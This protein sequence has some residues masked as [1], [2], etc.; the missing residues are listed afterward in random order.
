MEKRLFRYL[1]PD[2]IEIRKGSFI[3]K[4]KDRVE[5]LPYKTARVDYAL[6]D[7]T[8]GPFNWCVQ[9]KTENNILFAGIGIKDPVS[10]VFVFKWNAGD[11]AED[12][13][14]YGKALAS[15]SV[16]RSGFSWGLG[17]ELYGTPRVVVPN[18]NTSYKCTEFECEDGKVVKYTIVDSKGEQVYHYEPGY[19][20]VR[21]G[22]SELPEVDRQLPWVEQ[23][24][25]FCTQMKDQTEDPDEH[26][27]LRAFYSY[28]KPKDKKGLSYGPAKCYKFFLSDVKDGTIEIDDADPKHP[29][30]IWKG[31]KE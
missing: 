23:L 25:S 8:F 12:T 11:V 5:L 28:Y 20:S 10:G 7:E 17:T 15:D 6:L 29:K 24:L 22:K 4:D 2:E 1:K 30:A 16:K 21:S 13:V 18:E 19:T 26:I 31:R 14:D 27:K 9:Y 3:G